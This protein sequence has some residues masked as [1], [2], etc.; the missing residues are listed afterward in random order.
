MSDADIFILGSS[1]G[2]F[3]GVVF[4]AVMVAFAINSNNDGDPT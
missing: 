4:M 2:F 3:A 1:I